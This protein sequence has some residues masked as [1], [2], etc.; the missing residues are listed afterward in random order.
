[1][2]QPKLL[3]LDEPTVGIDAHSRDFILNSLL[4]LKETGVAVLYTTHY[5][6]E[7]E[8]IC[9]TIAIMDAGRIILQGSPWDLLR[10]RGCVDLG[11]L[12]LKVTGRSLR[13]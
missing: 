3:L 10:Q 4:R 9:D 2:H 12:F 5:M 11:E 7:A 6:E 8:K 1:L 13:D